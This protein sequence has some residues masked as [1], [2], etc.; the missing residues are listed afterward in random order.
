MS[1]ALRPRGSPPAAALRLV[2][3]GTQDRINKAGLAPPYNNIYGRYVL[4]L[5]K[6]FKTRTGEQ[7][8]LA[9]PLVI[10]KWVRLGPALT[11]EAIRR[12]LPSTRVA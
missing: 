4:D 11:G 5:V 9:I 1:S 12:L 8:A 6:T 2:K 3:V 7:L 10:R